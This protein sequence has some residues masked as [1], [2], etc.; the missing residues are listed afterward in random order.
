[1]GL[2]ITMPDR[3][4]RGR[5]RLF[6]TPMPTVGVLLLVAACSSNHSVRIGWMSPNPGSGRRPPTDATYG[7]RARAAARCGTVLDEQIRHAGLSSAHLGDVKR[8]VTRALARGATT[9]PRRIGSCPSC[10]S[11]SFLSP[12]ALDD[13]PAHIDAPIRLQTGRYSAWSIGQGTTQIAPNM[14][15]VWTAHRYP[16]VPLASNPTTWSPVSPVW[17]SMGLGVSPSHGSSGWV[18]KLPLQVTLCPARI[19]RQSCAPNVQSMVRSADGA[20][21]SW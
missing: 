14:V 10:G 13:A 11:V 21:R 3:K 7:D 9:P 5:M 8:S 12:A 20:V 17:D 16:K 2:S 15:V 6:D 18:V 19:F 4:R 1:M